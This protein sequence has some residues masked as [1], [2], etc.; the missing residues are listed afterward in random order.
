V[1]VVQGDSARL[2]LVTLGEAHDNRRE[3]LSGLTVG[4]KI[5]VTPPPLL[6]DGSQVAIQE[7]GK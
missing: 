2:R 4:E 1:Y 7:S 6:S 5:I 3:I